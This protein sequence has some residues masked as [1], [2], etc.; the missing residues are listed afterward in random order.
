MAQNIEL[1][2]DVLKDKYL[3]AFRNQ[4]GIKPSPF[5]EMIAKPELS[6]QTIKAA[7]TFGLN[8]GTGFGDDGSDTPE[9]GPQMYKGFEIDAV[10]LYCNVEISDKTVK[11]GSNNASA[12]IDTVDKEVRSAFDSANWNLGRALFMDGTGKLC[13]VNSGEG[14]TVVV[15]DTRFLKEG[16]I[17]D[18]YSDAGVVTSSS[19][20]IM[21][22]DRRNGTV[23]FSKSVSA[24]EG[25]FITLQKSYNKEITG[26][27]AIFDD[28]ITTIYGKSKA[29]NP[30]IKPI[31]VD[32]EKSLTD[33]VITD[34][35]RDAANYKN[36]DIDLIMMGDDAF[37]AYQT[38]MKEEN[39]NFISKV[40]NLKFK[41]GHTG[42]EVLFGNKTAKVVNESF[43]PKNEVW[44]VCTKDWKFESTKFDF[45]TYNSSIFTLVPGKNY[46]RALL[47]SY[48][49]LICENPGGCI[50][51]TNCELGA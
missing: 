5:L 6:N 47:A 13:K 3:P 35:M 36:T 38:Y 42:F 28:S 14:S 23:S 7:A 43:V 1:I 27:G 48:G 16:M 9:S 19:V 8:G 49:N 24:N 2:S 12:M 33:I 51:I 18:I 31:V 30:W 15:D 40:D 10:N 32:A 11:L 45:V 41:G 25:G 20:R 29:E 21:S 46:Y 44:G 37:T 39:G 34:A 26:L 4:I 50:R 22:I 17:C